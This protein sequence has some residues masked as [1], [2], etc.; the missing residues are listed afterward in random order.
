MTSGELTLGA[1]LA[2]HASRPERVPNRPLDTN[3][4]ACAEQ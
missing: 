1:V 2:R 4:P 3:N